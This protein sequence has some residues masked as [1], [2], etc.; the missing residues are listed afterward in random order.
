MDEGLP[1]IRIHDLTEKPSAAELLIRGVALSTSRL[2]ANLHDTSVESI[3]QARVATRRLRSDLRTFGPFFTKGAL[4]L[5]RQLR[6]LAG[7]LGEVRDRDVFLAGV[8]AEAGL[9]DVDDTTVIEAL[10][11]VLK[12]RREGDVERL[13]SH[14]EGIDQLAARLALWSCSP[15]LGK[16]AEKR[17]SKVLPPLVRSRWDR[18]AASVEKLEEPSAAALHRVRI[19]TKRVRYGAELVA[20]SIGGKSERFAAAAA[21]LQDILGD[22]HDA[23]VGH[24]ILRSAARRLPPQHAAALGQLAGLELA[25]RRQ[26]ESEWREAYASMRRLRKW[27]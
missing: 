11:N 15:P 4:Q 1:Q 3:H 18:L 23:V 9:F 25:K 10:T 16:R 19:L 5:S 13:R 24:E 14:V 7:L 26:A 17:G 20:P 12:R 27:M 2:F 8:S 6:P 21:N 22:H